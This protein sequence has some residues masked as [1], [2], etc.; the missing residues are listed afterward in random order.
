MATPKLQFNIPHKYFIYYEKK[1]GEIIA[2][3]NEKSNRYE[4]GIEVEFDVA[5]NFLSGKWK[6]RDYQVGYH[7]DSGKPTILSLT[8]EFSGYNFNNKVFEWITESDEYTDCTVEWNLRDK[9]WNFSLSQTFKQEYNSILSP[10]LVFFVTLE[11][12]SDFLIRTIFISTQDLLD[13]TCITVP[14]ESTFELDINKIAI[15][16]KLVFK[17]YK[18][19][20]IHE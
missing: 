15:S 14:F 7:K 6:F 8:T 5:K 10:N 2:V 16:S 20:V 3:S 1:S 19:K 4:F 18:L 17:N 13:S 12:D 9:V 11:N